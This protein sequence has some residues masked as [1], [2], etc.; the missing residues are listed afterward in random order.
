[1][2]GLVGCTPMRAGEDQR[3]MGCD[4][5]RGTAAAVSQV[6]FS[7]NSP[8]GGI[9]RCEGL[10]SAPL[11]SSGPRLLLLDSPSRAPWPVLWNPLAEPVCSGTNVGDPQPVASFSA[12]SFQFL[13]HLL[14]GGVKRKR[15]GTRGSA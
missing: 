15:G 1:M 8:L 7:Q 9:G 6:A 3:F 12:L 2:A 10:A 4:H 11:P 5:N 14:E 13:S